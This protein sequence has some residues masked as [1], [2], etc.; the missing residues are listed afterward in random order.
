V[1]C[2]EPAKGQDQAV[3]VRTEPFARGLLNIRPPAPLA[4]PAAGVRD[5]RESVLWRKRRRHRATPVVLPDGL[6]A[7]GGVRFTSVDPGVPLG[8]GLLATCPVFHGPDARIASASKKATTIAARVVP[9]IELSRS[10]RSSMVSLR[11]MITTPH[12][13][14][15]NLDP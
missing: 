3:E 10:W 13:R 7:G 5:G 2:Q 4:L 9:L 11:V 12:R 8:P 15:D 14:G 1:I 6:S